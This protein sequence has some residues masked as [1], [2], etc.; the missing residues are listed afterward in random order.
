[1]KDQLH[2]LLVEDSETDAKLVLRSLQRADCA[3]HHQRVDTADAMRAAL[4]SGTWHAI[5]SDWQMPKFSGLAALGVMKEMQFDL[6][7]IIVSGTVGEEVAADAMRAGASDY[8]LKD[9]LARLAP[10]LERELFEKRTREGR[11]L[12]EKAWRTSEA[13]FARLYESGIVGIVMAD[14][15]GN[16]VEANDAYLHMLGY[17]RAEVLSGIARWVDITPPE[18]QAADEVALEELKSRGVANPW[19]KEMIRKDGTRVPVLIGIA[20]L[21]GPNCIAFLADLSARKATEAALRRSEE[22]LRQVQ[23]MDAI[24]VL[25]GGVAHDFNNILTVILSYCELIMDDLQPQDPLRA[26]IGEIRHAGERATALTHQLLAFS[27]QQIIESTIIDLNDVVRNLDKMLRRL[28]REDVELT[29]LPA[30]D[31]GKCKSDV[32]QIEQVIMNL[33]VNARDAMPEGGKLTIETANVD[34]DEGFTSMHLGFK[35]GRYVMLAVSDTGHGMDKATQARIFEP[36]FTTKEKGKGTGLGLSTVFGIAEQSGGGVWVYS[37]LG[38]G[39]TFKVYLP[40]TEETQSVA[41]PSFPA[42]SGRGSETILLVEDEDQI[43]AVT[44]AVLQRNGYHV[45]ETRNGGEALLTCERHAGKIDLLVTDVV[46]PQM[47]GAEL[48]RRLFLLRPE[49]RVL[50]MSGYTDG[51]LVDQLAA[52]AAFLQKPLTPAMLTR[53]VREVL[54]AP[55]EPRLQ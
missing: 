43:R 8:V 17:S 45:L 15:L 20:M 19:E 27:R 42:P 2:L 24:G 51:A 21:D 12:A 11:R 31:L 53:K 14:V 55:I 13:R 40:R 34:L 50:F 9:K 10:A 52:G 29:T 36:F 33:V 38:L 3:I 6:P 39:T 26:D 48:A 4:E 46:M 7:F 30:A 22:Q 32:G 16:V 5:I 35:P 37:E 41:A 44:R 49:M 23:K 18:W 1:V 47:N 28:I 54:D 25:A